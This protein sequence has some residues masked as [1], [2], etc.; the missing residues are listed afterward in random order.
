MHHSRHETDSQSNTRA[1]E[2]TE[3]FRC[4]SSCA[5]SSRPRAS[6]CRVAFEV[7]RRTLCHREHGLIVKLPRSCVCKDVE[8]NQVSRP[9]GGHDVS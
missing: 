1:D 7:G 9:A 2:L 5:I 3:T 8:L 4:R 6:R